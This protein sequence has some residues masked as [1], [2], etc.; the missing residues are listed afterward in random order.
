MGSRDDMI[1][2]LCTCVCVCVYVCECVRMYVHT[3][4]KCELKSSYK[5]SRSVCVY[6][7]H[8]M[9]I[10]KFKKT[11]KNFMSSNRLVLIKITNTR[12]KHQNIFWRNAN[13]VNG[14]KLKV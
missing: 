3:Q 4:K 11:F 1:R 7:T 13:N 14:C 9:M 10:F 8:L 5:L 12:N 2:S 6:M